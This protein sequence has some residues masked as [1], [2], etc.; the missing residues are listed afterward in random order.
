FGLPGMK[1][2]QFAFDGDPD[3][4]YLPHQHSFESVVYTGT[5]D[6]D[7]TLGWYQSLDD[8]TR[9]YVCDYLGIDKDNDMPW[10][11]IRAALASVSCLAVIPLQDLLEL[12]NEHRMNKPGTS[13]GNWQWRFNWDQVPDDLASRL[14]HLLKLYGRTA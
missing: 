1:I 7:T 12:G 2:L 8:N 10:P 11:L 6:N 9:G 4:A 13:E 14:H 3:N 5:H